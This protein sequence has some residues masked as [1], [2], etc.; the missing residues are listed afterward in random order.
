[1]IQNYNN[2]KLNERKNLIWSGIFYNH[3]ELLTRYLADDQIKLQKNS[4]KPLLYHRMLSKKSLI[5]YTR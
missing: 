2:I 5:L 1:M 4:G 3:D